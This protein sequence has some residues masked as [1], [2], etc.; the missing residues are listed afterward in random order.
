MFD[1][2][3][4][5]NIIWGYSGPLKYIQNGV[6]YG[7]NLEPISSPTKRVKKFVGDDASKED[8]IEFEREEGV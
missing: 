1:E 2:T 5:H 8:T 7:P 3:R 6:E 4:P